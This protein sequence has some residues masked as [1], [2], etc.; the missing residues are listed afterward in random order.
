MRTFLDDIAAVDWKDL[1]SASA[2]TREAARR[3]ASDDKTMRHLCD[4]VLRAGDSDQTTGGVTHETS[5]RIYEAL[6][7]RYFAVELE[8]VNE[9][10]ATPAERIGRPLTR[11]VVAG[12]Y[13][14]VF[15]VPA[16]QATARPVVGGLAPVF[17][18]TERRGKSYTIHPEV[19]LETRIAPRSVAIAIHGP[20]FESEGASAAETSRSVRRLVPN[21]RQT[22]PAKLIQ[23]WA[24]LRDVGVI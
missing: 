23:G 21:R 11:H 10:T 19:I 14:H 5:I 9:A 7:D 24:L 6:A 3:L 8:V 12:V 13:Y 15:Y 22:A 20:L 2:T 1:E 17:V 18:R 4:G 16:E